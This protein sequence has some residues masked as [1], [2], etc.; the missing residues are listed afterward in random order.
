MLFALP[1]PDTLYQ[2][3]L[4]RDPSYDGRAYVCVASTGIFC[5]LT[6]P[7]RKPLR[8]NCTFHETA[9][10]CIA[11]G[12]RPCKRCHPL[13]PMAESDPVIARLLDALDARPAFR[14]S[15]P[16]LLAMGLD[17][18]TVRRA[19]K[20][21]FGMTFLEMA[22]QRRLRE[23][24]TALASGA[25]VIEAQLEAGFES[26]SAFRTGFS[27]ILGVAPG[28]LNPDALLRADWIATPLGD[29]VS[30]C[31]KGHL[32]L[33]EFMDRKALPRELEK[34][35][36]GAGNEIG[37]GQFAPSEQIRLELTRFF[38]GE[39][40]D[41]DTPLALHGSE[42]TKSVWRALRAIPAGETRSYGALAQALG[43]PSAVRAVAQANG[44]NQIALV[45]PC[46]RVIGADGALTGYGGGLWR[47]QRLLEIERG[48]LGG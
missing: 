7:A 46:H 15:E 8:A 4:D 11:A 37:V 45:I 39:S 24:F 21:Q 9:G 16:D 38:A 17:P 13:K 23:G 27:K 12:F 26:A 41:F 42:F 14:W 30:V 1:D 34:L 35:R 33:L 48:Y 6:C 28:A 29:M 19:F 5:R 25:P 47:K 10:D 18:S 43:R 32:H 36:K 31:S 2:A 20:R 3:L 40:A 22:R 44:A